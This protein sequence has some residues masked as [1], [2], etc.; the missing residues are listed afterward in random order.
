MLRHLWE[1]MTISVRDEHLQALAKLSTCKHMQA[2][3]SALQFSCQRREWEAEDVAHLDGWEPENREYAV[4]EIKAA[5]KSPAA[6]SSQSSA[7]V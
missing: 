6:A 2:L 3:A 7:L 4:N 5:R 1:K